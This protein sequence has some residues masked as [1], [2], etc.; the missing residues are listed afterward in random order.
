M[1]ED[2]ILGSN[3]KAIELQKKTF[4]NKIKID[5]RDSSQRKKIGTQQIF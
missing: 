5:K 3:F 2:A 1:K 4:K